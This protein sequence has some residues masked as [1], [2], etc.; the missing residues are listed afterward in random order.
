MW[1]GDQTATETI[2]NNIK[3]MI[4]NLMGEMSSVSLDEIRQNAIEIV[5]YIEEKYDTDMTGDMLEK[6]NT[7]GEGKQDQ[8]DQ[9]YKKNLTLKNIDFSITYF[10]SR[11]FEPFN[12]KQRKNNR[13]YFDASLKDPVLK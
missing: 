8:T 13:N 5:N 1:F 2:E 7:S 4:N 9:S 6:M 11:N 10:I 3:Q 12:D